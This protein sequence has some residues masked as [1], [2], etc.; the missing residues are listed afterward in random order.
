MG[1][2]TRKPRLRV[3]V[4][5]EEPSTFGCWCERY[6]G[7]SI[8]TALEIF[9]SVFPPSAEATARERRFAKVTLGPEQMERTCCKH[10]TRDGQTA[11]TCPSALLTAHGSSSAQRVPG[12]QEL[13]H[14]ST[15]HA[16]G[17]HAMTKGLQLG[18]GE[19]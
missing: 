1:A 8:D 13:A 17:L 14:N 3:R 2:E 6:H 19:D 18:K 5:V 7:V 16:G 9:P 11:A 10:F 15:R 12:P 4:A